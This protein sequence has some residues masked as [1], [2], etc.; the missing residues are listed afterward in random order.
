MKEEK[1]IL[2]IEDDHAFRQALK[3][4][5]SREGFHIVEADSG[6]AGLLALKDTDVDLVLLDFYLGDMTGAELLDLAGIL[7]PKVVVL[8]A[9]GDMEIRD[10]V[11][12]RRVSRCLTKPIRRDDLVREIRDVLGENGYKHEDVILS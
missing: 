12:S 3:N 11:L 7:R 4:V 5:L 1:K 9:H 6:K 10:E 8:T 2:L